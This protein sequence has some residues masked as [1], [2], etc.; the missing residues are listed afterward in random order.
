MALV[1]IVN[2]R[3]IAVKPGIRFE[4]S[5]PNITIRPA[6]MAIRLMITW[7]IVNV[8]KLIPSI[9]MRPLRWKPSKGY[10]ASRKI[11]TRITCGFGKAGMSLMKTIN[12]SS[13]M[14]EIFALMSHMTAARHATLNN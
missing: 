14:H 8:A 10:D 2:S 1:K 4:P 9:M 5:I 7:T 6:T 12:E 3:K 11:S 13:M